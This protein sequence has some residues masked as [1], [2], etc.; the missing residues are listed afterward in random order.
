MKPTALRNSGVP[1]MGP[2]PSHWSVR[3]VKHV[4]D[5]LNHRRSSSGGAS[6][7][8]LEHIES[9]TGRFVSASEGLQTDAEST[10]SVFDAGDVLFGKLRPYLAKVVVASSP[11]VC[12][13]EILV[14]RPTK[15]EPGYLK[16]SM[17]LDGFIQTVSSATYG[18]K[19]PRAEPDAVRR[20][21]VP[22]PPRHEQIAIVNYLTDE[23]GRLDNLIGQKQ[24]LADL[25]AEL[26]DNMIRE[27][28]TG[29]HI[30]GKMRNTG[31]EFLPNVPETWQAVPIGRYATI[32]NGSTPLKSNPDYWDDGSFPWLNSAVVNSS[33][34][35]AASELVTDAALQ[36][37][38][39]PIVPPGSVLIALTGQGKT[40]G[41]VA[42]LRIEATINQHLAFIRTDG[43]VLDSEYHYWTLKAMYEEIR[44]IS[45]GQGGT[46]GALTCDELARIKIP[47]PP[48]NEQK[49]I[50]RRLY[51][52]TKDVNRLIQHVE[53]EIEKL[54]ELR[55]A[56]IT[57]AVLGRIDLSE[58]QSKTDL[59]DAAA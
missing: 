38:H 22:F 12:S 3:R 44:I 43:D 8:G 4:A 55:S 25:V 31:D 10:V 32:G 27:L 47:L 21:F 11:G 15:I 30:G 36:Q 29:C 2:I 14:F 46:K 37:C 20:M 24:R 58:Y 33:D 13:S 56:T 59:E 51:A 54:K 40:R 7:V 28:T 39:L 41:Q 6:Y 1:W 18:S 17:L 53:T 45:D 9:Q 52:E 5:L 26:R 50:A 19:M 16:M 35:D 57:D 23:T 48:L 42:M 49:A 34:V